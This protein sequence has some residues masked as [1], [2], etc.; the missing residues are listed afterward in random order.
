MSYL[1]LA[2][3]AW[4]FLAATLVGIGIY[5]LGKI[6]RRNALDAHTRQATELGNAL[7]PALRV[8]RCTRCGGPLGVG[9][10]REHIHADGR[11]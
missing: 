10:A 11:D 8:R 1:A 7:H 4:G 6:K 5:E 2:A 3:M 9:P